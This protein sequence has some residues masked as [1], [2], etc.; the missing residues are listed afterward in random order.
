MKTDQLCRDFVLMHR[1][2]ELD[3]I[4]AVCL[5]RDRWGVQVDWHVMSDVLVRM[6]ERAEVDYSRERGYDRMT[7]YVVRG[8]LT[9]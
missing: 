7:R 1:G 8:G 3:A 5:M 6:L 9:R 4:E 2:E